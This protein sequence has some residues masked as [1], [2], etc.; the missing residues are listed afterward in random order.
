MF[1]KIKNGKQ[2]LKL[3]TQNQAT[4]FQGERAMDEKER[5]ARKRQGRR[6]KARER[7][8]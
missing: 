8:N 4:F 3:K 7:K 6:I 1:F 5:H 2:K